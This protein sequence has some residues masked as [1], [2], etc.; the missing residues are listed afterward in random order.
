M[1]KDIPEV[2]EI[3]EKTS[4]LDSLAQ[5]IRYYDEVLTQSAGNY[6]F[7][8][9]KK[10][11]KKWEERYRSVEPKL[12]KVIPEA[13]KKGERRDKEFFFSVNKANPALVEME[14]KSIGLA[15]ND[16]TDDAIRISESNS[17]CDE[18]PAY[19][20]GFLNYVQRRGAPNMM[21]HF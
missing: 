14:Y 20:Q 16:Q 3:V 21:N 5:L 17:Y 9:D 7:T 6:A 10:A 8:A 1:N 12:D 4:H 18:K 19:E 13:I 11:D 15:N 2:I